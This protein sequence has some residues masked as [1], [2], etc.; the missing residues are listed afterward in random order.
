MQSPDCGKRP[1]SRAAASPCCLIRQWGIEYGAGAEI[2]IFL[3]DVSDIFYFSARGRG[4][5][6]PRRQGRGGVVFNE[7]PRAGFSQERGRAA[8]GPGG[9]FAGTLGRGGLIFVFFRG[10]NSH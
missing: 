7:N 8:E 3:V 4:S 6:S 1:C 2:L 9:C 10:R 5:R